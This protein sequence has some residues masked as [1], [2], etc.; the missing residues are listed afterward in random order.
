[1]GV[2]C[3]VASIPSTSSEARIQGIATALGEVLRTAVLC[4]ILNGKRGSSNWPRAHFPFP[5]NGRWAALGT[6]Q[7]PV[8]EEM[9]QS[10]GK[11]D[12]DFASKDCW[13]I[14][15]NIFHSMKSSNPKD[16]EFVLQRAFRDG[17][18]VLSVICGPNWSISRGFSS[19][20][21]GVVWH[22]EEVKYIRNA[23]V[24]A[25]LEESDNCDLFGRSLALHR[26]SQD[27][28]SSQGAT[29]VRQ[30][31]SE[32][33]ASL[34]K[35]ELNNTEKQLQDVMSFRI[36][37]GTLLTDPVVSGDIDRVFKGRAAISVLQ[38][39]PFGHPCSL[40]DCVVVESLRED[41]HTGLPCWLNAEN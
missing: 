18:I 38:T 37:E 14:G 19:T 8:D 13:S 5:Q 2:P 21:C 34:Q 41:V 25:R 16:W 15:S 22:Q 3:I 23:G 31:Q 32:K 20:R 40:L 27:E 7:L 17:D 35:K 28:P 33:V 6:E 4:S 29:F 26:A 24:H 9:I 30:M 12:E 39:W 10:F 11:E 36:D 1:M